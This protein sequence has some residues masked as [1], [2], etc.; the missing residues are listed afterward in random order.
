MKKLSLDF[1]GD[2][3]TVPFPKDFQDLTDKIHQNYQLNLS[4]ILA[5]DISYIKNKVK[6]TI[7][8][9]NDFKIFIISKVPS[10]SL[11]IVESPELNEK[12]MLK[13]SKED[14]IRLE[15][16][17]K[18]KTEIRFKIEEKEKESQKRFNEIK[19]QLVLL[20]QQKTQLLNKLQLSM[21]D[22][23]K[24]EKELVSKIMKLSKELKTAPVF[25]IPEKGPLPVKGNTPKEKEYLECIRKYSA[26]LKLSE[27][28]FAIP[29]K[30]ID[31]V[32]RKIKSLHKKFNGNNR[33]NEEDIF[34]LKKEENLINK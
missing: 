29:R 9:E 12:K 24:E 30:S 31:E 6:R 16:L 23:N 20:D 33:T 21:K 22:Q 19:Y 28:M 34:D 11:E 1:Y 4:D 14:K 15:T 25:K 26:C 7:K 18:K 32:D 8:S 2:K 27:K 17:K 10:L 5:I 13:I 3:I